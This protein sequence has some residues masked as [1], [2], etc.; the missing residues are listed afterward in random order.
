MTGHKRNSK[1]IDEDWHI[2]DISI[3]LCKESLTYLFRDLGCWR[4]GDPNALQDKENN[5]YWLNHE[6]KSKKRNEVILNNFRYDQSLGERIWGKMRTVSEE[7]VDDGRSWTL[8]ASG[9]DEDTVFEKTFSYSLRKR[10]TEGLNQSYKAS[11]SITHKTSAEAKVEAGPASASA[12][13][14]TTLTASFEA[15]AGVNR[16]KE[17]DEQTQDTIKQPIPVKAGKKVLA[18]IEKTKLITERPYKIQGVLDFDISV[19]LENWAGKDRNGGLWTDNYN[20]NRF[21]FEGVTGFLKF[22]N[23]YDT[24]FP[25]MAEYAA[26]CG[27]VNKNAIAAWDWLENPV[28]RAVYAEGVRRRTFE[29]NAHIAVKNLS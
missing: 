5:V 18:Y 23:G 4:C 6:R 25:R 1:Y 19:D 24:R 8:D 27:S 2:K 15:T 20:R 10:E 13:T 12:K 17:I 3:R 9:F 26:R 14:E 11:A 7:V 28:N 29:N 21:S 16:E 22:L